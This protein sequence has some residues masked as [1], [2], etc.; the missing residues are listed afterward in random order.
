MNIILLGPPGAG[1]GTQARLLADK[2]R[3]CQIATGE[4]L[5]EEVA[6]GSDIGLKVKPIMES[7]KFPSD[8]LIMDVLAEKISN[9]ECGNGVILDGV[10][11]TLNQAELVDKMF[12]KLGKSL[13]FVVQLRVD[14]E[15]LI[16]R[17]SGRY[18][19]QSCGAAYADQLNPT[20]VKGVCDRCGAHEFIRRPDD[21]AEVVKTRL[22]VYQKQTEPLVGF[23]SKTNRLKSVDG[24]AAVDDVQSQIVDII[25]SR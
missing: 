3:L 18:T 5:R 2:L 23:Y 15:Q 24:M 20:K 11:R 9:P 6:K 16:K 12:E 17:I 19:C 22:D 8:D 14:D 7:G 4:I 10:P 13:D 25:Q 1:K 21:S